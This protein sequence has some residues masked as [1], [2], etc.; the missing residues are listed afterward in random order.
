MLDQLRKFILDEDNEGLFELLNTGVVKP[1]DLVKAGAL[2]AYEEEDNDDVSREF[3]PEGDE[4]FIDNENESQ[5]QLPNAGMPFLNFTEFLNQSLQNL[6]SMFPH[7]EG[8]NGEQPKMDLNSMFSSFANIFNPKNMA[9]QGSQCS[10]LNCPCDPCECDPCDC[11]PDECDQKNDDCENPD[12]P[13]DPCDP[14][15]CGQNEN[16]EVDVDE[17]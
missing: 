12:C 2:L 10:N 9:E 6:Q 1:M 16:E 3:E 15:E 14:G 7:Q 17:E 8:D 4:Q 11:N 13:C 5:T